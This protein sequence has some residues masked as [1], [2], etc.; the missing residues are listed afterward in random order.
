[1]TRDDSTGGPELFLGRLLWGLVVSVGFPGNGARQELVWRGTSFTTTCGS[2]PKLDRTH[3]RSIN[4]LIY[5]EASKQ[6]IV[7]FCVSLAWKGQSTNPCVSINLFS[8]MFLWKVQAGRAP[9]ASRRSCSHAPSPGHDA[10]CQS[11]LKRCTGMKIGDLCSSVLL[12][13]SSREV[14]FRLE[15]SSHVV[16]FVVC[17]LS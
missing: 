9:A 17:V 2:S 13:R 1:M 4:L 11:S 5:V 14:C 6:I 3:E 7:S 16:F 12:W 10:T 8:R 15:S